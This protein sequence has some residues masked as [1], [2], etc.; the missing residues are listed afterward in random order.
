ML[1][2]DYV[3]AKAAAKESTEVVNSLYNLG[4]PTLLTAVEV[5][6]V[7]SH[8]K[9]YVKNLKLCLHQTPAST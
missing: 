5:Y 6:K 8:V 7:R 4:P 1:N 2:Q 9:M 3:Y